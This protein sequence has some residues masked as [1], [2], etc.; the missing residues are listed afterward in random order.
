MAGIF[1]ML[2]ESLKALDK[3]TRNSEIEER[4]P[5]EHNVFGIN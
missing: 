4:K 1:M 2:N 3:E 5:S